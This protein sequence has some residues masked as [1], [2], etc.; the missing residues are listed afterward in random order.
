MF[1]FPVTAIVG[2]PLAVLVAWPLRRLRNQWHHVLILALTMGVTAA[3]ILS[4]LSY[5][6]LVEGESSPISILLM[7]AGVA[8]CMAIGRASVMK[9]VSRRN[10]SANEVEPQTSAATKSHQN[11]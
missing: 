8:L 6:A 11:P 3:A 4:A 5:P 9:L 10:E 1:G 7:A 2:L